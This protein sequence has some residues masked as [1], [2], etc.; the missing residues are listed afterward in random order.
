VRL[1]R[2]AAGTLNADLLALGLKPRDEESPHEI[3]I[4]RG[5]YVAVPLGREDAVAQAP[6]EDGKVC[7]TRSRALGS[8]PSS[9]TANLVAM[10]FVHLIAL[11]DHV[12]EVRRDLAVLETVD[13]QLDLAGVKG[14]GGIEYERC[15][16]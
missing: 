15:A 12:V 2:I 9:S 10:H 4:R 6:P 8:C 14:R 5:V 1:T 7:A 13:R 16:R 11:H 3:C